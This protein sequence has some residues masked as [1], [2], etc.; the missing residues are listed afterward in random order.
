V[1]R[2]ACPL[3][4][5]NGKAESNSEEGWTLLPDGSLFTV[6]VTNAGQSERYSPSTDTWILA[7]DT[8]VP[9]ATG[10]EMGPQVLLPN[11]NVFSAGSTGNT[12]LYNAASES[13]TAGPDFPT[14]PD[15]PLAMADA[16]GVLLPSGSVLL[17]ASAHFPPSLTKYQQLSFFFEFNGTSITPEP[18]PSGNTT[19]S[20]R[21]H[22]LLH[23]N[24]KVLFTDLGNAA[25]YTRAGNPSPAWAPGITAAPA[26]VQPGQTYT[27]SGTQFNGLSQAVMYGDDYQAATNFPLVQIANNATGHLFYCFTAGRTT[28]APWLS[29]P[30]PQLFQRNL[31]CHGLLT[32][33][34]RPS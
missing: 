14:G 9:L 29:P 4:A 6:N 23:P 12:A 22:L 27:I 24:G 20:Y 28:I 21:S 13:W 19:G 26:T 11:G 8:I 25:I 7:G 3:D 34:H 30:A 2:L 10:R 17:A 31:T 1:A 18:A 33:V 32:P 15:G 16:P 5:G